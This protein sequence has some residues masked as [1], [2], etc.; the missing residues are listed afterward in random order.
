MN[1]IAEAEIAH[2]EDRLRKA[3][4]ASDVA[5]LDDLLAP[6]LTFTNHLGQLTGKQEEL[7]AYGSGMLKVKE[8]KPSEQNVQLRGNVAVV[9]VRTQLSGTYN[10]NPADGDFRFTRVWALSADN[11]WHVI[12]AHAGIVA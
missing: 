10:G 3:M 8:L 11:T 2:A 5:A 12:A 6:E 1:P 9:S 7:E 4:L